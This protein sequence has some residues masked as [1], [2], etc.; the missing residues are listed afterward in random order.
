MKLIQSLTAIT[1]IFSSVNV[2]SL[3]S[4]GSC[5]SISASDFHKVSLLSNLQGDNI[6]EPIGIAPFDDKNGNVDVFYAQRHGLLMIYDAESDMKSVAM[7]MTNIVDSDFEY[8]CP[9]PEGVCPS[10]TGRGCI[11]TIPPLISDRQAEL[12]S[13]RLVLPSL[14]SPTPIHR[15]PYES[16]C[17]SPPV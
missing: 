4:L 5:P 14:L 16:N 10:A 1:L 8:V 3:P 13:P 6:N 2:W 11:L 17:D 9:M 7:D 15:S 12:S